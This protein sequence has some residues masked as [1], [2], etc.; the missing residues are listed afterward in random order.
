MSYILA[1]TGS[2]VYVI[3]TLIAVW[4]AVDSVI[5]A[6][7]VGKWATPVVRVAAILNKVVN[8]KNTYSKA[9][10]WCG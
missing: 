7:R 6:H 3:L 9:S 4:A 5:A 2:T 10:F 8:V 1:G